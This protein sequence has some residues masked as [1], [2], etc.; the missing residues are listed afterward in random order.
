MKKEEIL[1]TIQG[2]LKGD[3]FEATTELSLDKHKDLLV[4]MQSISE[5]ISDKDRGKILLQALTG[6]G[7]TIAGAKVLSLAL[8]DPEPTSSLSLLVVGGI[9]LMG[10]GGLTILYTLGQQW[11]VALSPGGI[12]L[13]PQRTKEIS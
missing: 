9:A 7:L 5:E 13:T 8:L 12:T 4:Y 2:Y 1:K 3:P 6:A 11:Q 10:L